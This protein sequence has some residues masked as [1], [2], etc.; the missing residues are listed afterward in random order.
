MAGPAQTPYCDAAGVLSRVGSLAADLRVDD[1]PSCMDDCIARASADI[2]LRL[3]AKHPAADFTLVARVYWCAVSLAARVLCRR[4]LNSVPDDLN[5]E[6]KDYEAQM[7]K[8][9]AGTLTLAA[10]PRAPGG[11]AVSNQHVQHGARPQLGVD[12]GRSTAPG[13]PARRRFDYGADRLPPSR[14]GR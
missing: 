3:R 13:D 5:D 8:L 12:R 2:D 14:S 10:L 7:D 11:V 1:D 9:A 4:R 6:C